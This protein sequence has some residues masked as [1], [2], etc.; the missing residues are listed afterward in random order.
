MPLAT[1]GPSWQVL[2][3]PALNWACHGNTLRSETL[4]EQGN[5]RGT[6]LIRNCTPPWH[7]HKALNIVLVWG[8]RE[9]LFLLSEV[10]LYNAFMAG[11]ILL[12]QED[13]L[14]GY[15]AHKKPPPPRTLQ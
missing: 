2:V 15:L 3:L 11:P 9:A 14:Q 12:R 4:V 8:L 6:S 10:P 5:Y 7:H 1:E 13:C